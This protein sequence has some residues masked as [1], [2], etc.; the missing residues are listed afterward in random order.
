M[1]Q[2]VSARYIGSWVKGFIK[3]SGQLLMSDGR[4]VVRHDWPGYS[5][6][7]A[8][9]S[10]HKATEKAKRR[11]ARRH[12]RLFGVWEAMYR[13]EQ[14][15]QLRDQIEAERIAKKKAEE[16]EHRRMLKE[17]RMK[18]KKCAIEAVEAGIDP[19]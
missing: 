11:A 6:I 13:A 10:V 1:T 12:K 17:R 2:G 15:E 3:G 18:G 16:A 5:F 8:V 7:E 9:Q 19:T 4:R 14:V